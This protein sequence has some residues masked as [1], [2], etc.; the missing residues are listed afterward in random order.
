MF[1]AKAME[2]QLVYSIYNEMADHLDAKGKLIKDM[3][4]ATYIRHINLI[5]DD[6]NSTSEQQRTAAFQLLR[7]FVDN[8]IHSIQT[9]ALELLSAANIDLEQKKSILSPLG[10]KSIQTSLA[11]QNIEDLA[12]LNASWNASSTQVSPKL[13]T[14][15]IYIIVI[16]N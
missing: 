10:M 1:T 2:N 6:L 12:T 16:S 11:N 14:C 5:K 8:T 15:F 3:D 9:D 4:N 7:I 13:I